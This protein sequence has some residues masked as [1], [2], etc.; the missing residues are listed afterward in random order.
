[1]NFLATNFLLTTNPHLTLEYLDPTKA[2]NRKGKN[3]TGEESSTSK[4]Q[5]KSSERVQKQW[6]GRRLATPA[7]LRQLRF[8]VVPKREQI[9]KIAG[10]VALCF[11]WAIRLFDVELD[12]RMVVDDLL[13][14]G[15]RLKSDLNRRLMN[16]AYHFSA[17]DQSRGCAG[18]AG[19]A[20][21]NGE[22]RY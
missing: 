14:L 13:P 19:E 6:H 18:E 3:L 20:Q 7:F 21:M 22:H 1:V 8:E 17:E 9:S 12:E 16:S 2:R 5:S 15:I 11:F 4:H 10:L